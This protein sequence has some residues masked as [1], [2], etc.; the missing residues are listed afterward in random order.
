V[1]AL[2][3]VL[4]VLLGLLV[5]ADRVAV[6]VA[7]DRVAGQVQS[8]G[9]LAGPPTVDIG[10]FPFLTQ[11][12]AG[13]YS[14]VRL[15]LSAEDLDKPGTSADVRLRGV[16]VPLSAVLRG[17]VREVPVDDVTG[18]ATLSYDLVAGQIG[19]GVTLAPDG[20]R[21]RVSRSVAVLGQTLPLTAVGRVSLDGNDVVY[22]VDQVSGAGIEVPQALLSRAGNLLAF[23]FPVPALPFGLRLTAVRPTDA[24][25]VVDVQATDTVLHG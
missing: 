22:A 25:L 1:K 8:S 15:Q 5:V 18:T 23:R 16:H 14:D 19:N 12:V 9:G 20:D 2:L 3:V 24:G 11:A 7:E 6:N 17:A 21:L 4:V 10:G 13:D